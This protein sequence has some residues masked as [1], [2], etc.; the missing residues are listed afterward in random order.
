MTSL[1]KGGAS[2]ILKFVYVQTGSGHETCQKCTPNFILNLHPKHGSRIRFVQEV[3]KHDE[4]IPNSFVFYAPN[5][6]AEEDPF[7]KSRN[8]MKKYLAV[9]YYR[10]SM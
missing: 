5:M 10:V 9:L 3:N 8:V 1:G 7:K 6:E 4:K 2:K